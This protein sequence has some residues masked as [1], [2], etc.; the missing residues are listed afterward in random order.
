[1][2]GLAQ[3]TLLEL[4]QQQ[5]G[6]ALLQ[7]PPRRMHL[8]APQPGQPQ[9][10]SDVGEPVDLLLGVQLV[11]QVLDGRYHLLRELGSV[12]AAGFVLNSASAAYAGTISTL[13]ALCSRLSKGPTS[14]C[15][16]GLPMRMPQ[17]L[18]T[19]EP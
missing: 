6:M 8:R 2:E 11:Q 5:L 16:F 7:G 15:L 12:R 13:R 9:L 19:D 1:M 3:V 10:G 4:G 14:A 18:S 17:M